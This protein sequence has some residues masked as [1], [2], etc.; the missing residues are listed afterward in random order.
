MGSIDRTASKSSMYNLHTDFIPAVLLQLVDQS[1]QEYTGVETLGQGS[2]PCINPT[3]S[4][5]H[6][7]VDTCSI[8]STLEKNHFTDSTFIPDQSTPFHNET[9]HG[10]STKVCGRI[11][12]KGR[13]K[14]LDPEEPLVA[15]RLWNFEKTLGNIDPDTATSEPLLTNDT[16]AAAVQLPYDPFWIDVH[17][18]DRAKF[19]IPRSNLK[20]E[21]LFLDNV[22]MVGDI[23]MLGDVDE[24][25]I[26]NLRNTALVG[27]FCFWYFCEPILTCEK[28]LQVCK[29]SNWWPDLQ[30]RTNKEPSGYRVLTRCKGTQELMKALIEEDHRLR[31]GQNGAWKL[32]TLFR[33]GTNLGTLAKIREEYSFWIDQVDEWA[34][35]NKQRRRARR[36]GR[37]YGHTFRDSELVD[38]GCQRDHIFQYHNRV[39]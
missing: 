2:N 38:G 24:G 33:N 10:E 21:K 12:S 8:A 32:V 3:L 28:V 20:F 11:S 13:E 16:I 23:F 5:P 36:T 27:S 4:S 1:A 22:L 17:K 19:D 9:E 7:P 31:S 29:A 30:I 39:L 14:V 35:R 15:E 26:Q 34:A 6:D 37:G 25:M 18:L